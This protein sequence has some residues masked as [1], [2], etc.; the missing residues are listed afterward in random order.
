MAKVRLLRPPLMA[1]IA[2]MALMMAV[3]VLVTPVVALLPV[4]ALAVSPFPSPLVLVASL[5]R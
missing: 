1:K 2:F 4:W 3:V 5:Q